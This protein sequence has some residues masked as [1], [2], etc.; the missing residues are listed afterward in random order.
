MI[1][2]ESGLTFSNYKEPLTKV[3]DGFGYYG[4]LM[5]TVDGS[6][7]Q[8]HIC[9]EL[10][11][12]LAIH[13]NN[14][15]E[16]KSRIYKNIF[17]LAYST[18]LVSE[19]RRESLKQQTLNWLKTLTP[20]EKEAYAQRSRERLQKIRREKL[21]FDTQS[22][23]HQLETRNKRGTCPDQLLAKITEVAQ[24]LG[25]TP[26]LV[27]FIEETGGQRYKHLIFATFGSWKEAVKMAKLPLLTQRRSRG[28]KKRYSDDELLEYI[29]IFAQ[30]HQRIPTATDCKRG[31][32]PYYESY[33]RFGGMPAAR[34]LADISQFLI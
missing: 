1:D 23:P 10:F 3:K 25:K 18:A 9:G 30:E 14:A 17:G 13:V 24:K 29:R 2:Q 5:S 26:S 22:H 8:C 6:K 15:H 32:L 21:N 28:F 31:L 20:E 19:T 7:V 27:E 34:E 33:R 12:H 16:I 4:V 11:E